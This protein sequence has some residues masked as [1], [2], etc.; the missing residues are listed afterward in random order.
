VVGQLKRWD[1]WNGRGGGGTTEEMGHLE[2]WGSKKSRP[3]G[4]IGCMQQFC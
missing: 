2:R 1:S 4:S 3:R